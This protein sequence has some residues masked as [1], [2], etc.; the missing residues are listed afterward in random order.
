LGGGEKL[1]LKEKIK[2]YEKG[3]NYVKQC[4]LRRVNQSNYEENKD[5][6]DLQ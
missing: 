5:S 4:L 6:V 3:K 1:D 2:E